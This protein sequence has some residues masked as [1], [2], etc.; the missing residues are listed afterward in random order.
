MTNEREGWCQFVRRFIK[1]QFTVHILGVTGI[2][3]HPILR[4]SEDGLKLVD[5]VRYDI[6]FSS[7]GSSKMQVTISTNPHVPS[8]CQERY[9][10]GGHGES[11][12]TDRSGLSDGERRRKGERGRDAWRMQV[13]GFS[14]NRMNMNS[15]HRRASLLR[16]R[17]TALFVRLPPR[18]LGEGLLSHSVL[19]CFFLST[20]AD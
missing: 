12:V 17:L 2:L 5:C 7:R 18:G 8:A 10:D 4:P 9:V 15:P 20:R 13:I 3:L 14:A 11:G 1:L 6:D 19:R 16:R